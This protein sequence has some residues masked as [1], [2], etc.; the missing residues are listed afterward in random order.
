MKRLIIR[1]MAAIVVI[2]A[3]NFEAQ[4]QTELRNAS[5]A[6]IGRATGNT[7]IKKE[8]ISAYT[9]SSSRMRSSD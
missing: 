8:W 7:G 1:V 9:F 5:N 2:L 4:A 6:Q 3:V